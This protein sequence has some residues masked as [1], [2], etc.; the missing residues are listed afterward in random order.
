MSNCDYNPQILSSVTIPGI[1]PPPD[2]GPTLTPQTTVVFTYDATV[3]TLKCPEPNNVL[4]R[5]THKVV[6]RSRAGTLKTV[7]DSTWAKDSRHTLTFM[8]L[9]RSDV[10]DFENLYRE[11]LGK[12]VVYTDYEG[13][14]WDVYLEKFLPVEHTTTEYGYGFQITL[15]GDLA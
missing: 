14:D 15:V 6:R 11:S 4:A 9:K 13:R 1:T 10:D 3:V 5:V 12:E 8:G 2:T 7:L